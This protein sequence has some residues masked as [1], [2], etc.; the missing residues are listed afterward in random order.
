[1]TNLRSSLEDITGTT[2]LLQTGHVLQKGVEIPHLGSMM[3]SSDASIFQTQFEKKA[4]IFTSCILAVKDLSTSECF[5]LCVFYVDTLPRFFSGRFLFIMY[6]WR[7]D[8]SNCLRSV[9]LCT[10]YILAL[11]VIFF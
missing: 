1:M 7:A 9:T 10:Q 2:H 4:L 6:F 5:F 11:S 3:R 8:D